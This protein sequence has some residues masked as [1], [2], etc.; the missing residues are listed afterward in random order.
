M[1]SL[2]KELCKLYKYLRYTHVSC[3][4]DHFTAS[5]SGMVRQRLLRAIASLQAVV[6]RDEGR[7]GLA[8][9]TKPDQLLSAAT[10]L[11]ALLPGAPTEPAREEGAGASNSARVVVLTGFPCMRDRSP[12]GETD[13]PAGAVA[14]ARALMALGVH[15]DLPIESH[16]AAVMQLCAEAHQ[17]VGEPVARVLSFPTDGWSAS[18]EARLQQMCDAASAV[19]C[20]ERAGEAA[21]GVCYT[22]RGFPMGE[23]LLQPRINAAVMNAERALP[24]VAIGDGGN[25]LGLGT[26]HAAV[27]ANIA[28]GDKIGCV[29]PSDALLVASVSNWGGYALSH[30][31]ALLAWGDG[32][33]PVGSSKPEGGAHGHAPQPEAF[34]RAIAPDPDAAGRAIIASNDGGVVDGING[35]GGGFVD[36]MP[37]EKQLSV[38]EELRSIT[39]ES[40]RDAPLGS[41]KPAQH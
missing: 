18:D 14:I 21:D 29:V 20:I 40:M 39:L 9:L 37:L 12:P 11:F 13:G 35:Q 22:M 31:L 38:V 3:V 24:S 41:G 8:P 36:G 2:Q 7:R 30:A 27:V 32:R 15:V 26:A 34:L 23:S 33:V 1:Y 6:Q 19:V 10:E 17:D 28:L 5:P 25:E 4:R 16:S